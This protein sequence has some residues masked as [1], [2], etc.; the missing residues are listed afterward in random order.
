M[1]KPCRL[2]SLAPSQPPV[3]QCIG[4][5]SR[6]PCSQERRV[7]GVLV[8]SSGRGALWSG[9]PSSALW[10]APPAECSP[11]RHP[12]PHAGG[13]QREDP[14]CCWG[15]GG[16]VNSPTRCFGPVSPGLGDTWGPSPEGW[17]REPG[18]RRP[19]GTEVRTRC[20][21]EAGGALASPCPPSPTY[22]LP[23]QAG[24]RVQRESAPCQPPLSASG[25]VPEKSFFGAELPGFPPLCWA[26][27]RAARS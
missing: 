16:V 19:G 22:H 5:V 21:P 14:E 10:P 11:L 23:R 27:S 12:C 26:H 1:H 3:G 24:S 6:P 7:W 20:G 18:R 4:N 25:P 15:A 2:P 13:Q 9:V 17:S 8:S